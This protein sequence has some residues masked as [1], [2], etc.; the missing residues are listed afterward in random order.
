[1]GSSGHFQGRDGSSAGGARRDGKWL[2]DSLASTRTVISSAGGCPG[3]EYGGGGE[4]RGRIARPA[5]EAEATV[6]TLGS[7]GVVG[8]AAS[9]DKNEQGSL[10]LENIFSSNG[11]HIL[12]LNIRSLLPKISEIRLLCRSRKAPVQAVVVVLQAR[13]QVSTAVRNGGFPCGL[14]LEW[15]PRATQ[16]A[17]QRVE[18]N[19]PVTWELTEVVQQMATGRSLGDDGLLVDFYKHFWGCI[20]VALGWTS[21]TTES[22]STVGLT[23]FYGAVLRAWRLLRPCRE[24]GLE[25]GSG[26]W[27]ETIFYNPLIKS[28]SLESATLQSWFTVVGVC[29]LAHLRQP[30]GCNSVTPQELAELMGVHSLRVLEKVLWNVQRALLGQM[31]EERNSHPLPLVKVTAAVGEWQEGGGKLSFSSPA[32]GNFQDVKLYQVCMKVRSMR[33]LQEVKQHQWQ[34][35]QGT[36]EMLGFR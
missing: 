30:G 34:E 33:A 35:E 16:A 7:D 26:L 17:E 19:S 5:S 23:D 36:Q 27:E 20:M 31:L 6:H 29:R 11:L 28:E 21:S 10:D 15:S 2:T 25:R 1:M 24:G 22:L 4:G 18:L 9:M 3:A 13:T 14:F 12:H 8:L 32:L